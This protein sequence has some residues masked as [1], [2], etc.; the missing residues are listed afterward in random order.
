M[1]ADRFDAV[2]RSLVDGGTSRRWVLKWLA[3]STLAA[4][5]A[6]LGLGNAGATHTGCYHVG[7]HCTRN[8]HCC[9]GRCRGRK[10]AKTCRAHGVGTCTR[11]KEYCRTFA[12]GCGGGACYCYRT[13]GDASFCSSGGGACMTCFKDADCVTAFGVAGMAC[14]QWCSDGGCDG[15]S[16]ACAAPCTT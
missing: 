3:G 10:G 2:T 5:A 9:S 14:I 12:T 4:L 7:K 8:G 1:D 11:E 16:T 6:A 13:T 15:F